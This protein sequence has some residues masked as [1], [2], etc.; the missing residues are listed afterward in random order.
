METTGLLLRIILATNEIKIDFGATAK[1]LGPNCTP[2]AVHQKLKK[3][4]RIGR[5]EATA[6]AA[7]AGTG[8]EAASPKKKP[9]RA[10]IAASKEPKQRKI[11]KAEPKEESKEKFKELV[12]ESQTDDDSVLPSPAKRPRTK[13]ALHGNGH[14]AET[15]LLTGLW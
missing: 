6:A 10:K 13:S 1:L 12:E 11:M 4:R 5:E 2:G 9:G 14:G 3:L 8:M 15:G 7:A